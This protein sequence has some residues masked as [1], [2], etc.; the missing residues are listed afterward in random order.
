MI[1][2]ER[3]KLF[4]YEKKY[5]NIGITKDGS[6][7]QAIAIP[8]TGHS[9]AYNMRIPDIFL[10]EEDL[11]DSAILAQLDTF[12]ILGLYVFCDLETYDVL[13]RFHDLQDIFLKDARN[14]RDLSFMNNTPDWFMLFIQGATLPNLNP[15]LHPVDPAKM[16]HSYCLGLYNC[17][18]G[19]ISSLTESDLHFHELLI[20]GGRDKADYARWKNVKSLIYH[21]NKLNNPNP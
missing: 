6:P 5:L 13:G 12:T 11:Y 16:R 8:W 10:C 4:S 2:A 17:Q 19:D 7:V 14:L 3:E 21:Y 1:Q 20:W 15:I 9:S 18:V